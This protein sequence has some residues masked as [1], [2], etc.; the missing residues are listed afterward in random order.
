LRN[1]GI[2]APL[3]GFVAA[4]AWAG[5]PPIAP[6]DQEKIITNHGIDR[7]DPYHW[8]F[9]PLV[10][11]QVVKPKP[12]TLAYLTAEEE[13][14]RGETASLLPLQE[15]L[16]KEMRERTP[17][18]ALTIAPVKIGNYLYSL[19]AVEGKQFRAYYRTRL[20]GSGEQKVLDL[21]EAAGGKPFIFVYEFLPS[22]DGRKL[23]YSSMPGGRE[24]SLYLKDLETGEVQTLRK[25]DLGV[26]VAEGTT[27][28]LWSA[29]EKS[30]F[31][32]VSDTAKRSYQLYRLKLGSG[33][34]A[35]LVYEEKDPLYVLGLSAS[36]DGKY[37]FRNSIAK[38]SSEV[39][40]LPTDK[41]DA[42]WKVISPRSANHIYRA[43][44]RN[45]WFYLWSNHASP[46]YGVYRTQ[47]ART[48]LA[49][50]Q[51]VVAPLSDGS[52]DKLY[53]F[54]NFYVYLARRLGVQSIQ[55]TPFATG[56]SKAVAFSEPVY[57]L[58]TEAIYTPEVM[59]LA[60]NWDYGAEGFRFRFSSMT[61]L[62][63]DIRYEV[64]SGKSVTLQETKLGES[65]QPAAYQVERIF[66]PS[67]NVEVPVSII[68]RK[69]TPKDGTAPLF[70]LGYG[71]YGLNFRMNDMQTYSPEVAASL[72]DRG[73]V[74]AIAHVRGGGEL[75]PAW[76]AGG[77]VM[78]KQNTFRDFIAVTEAL[79]ARK[80]AAKD[81]VAIQS[82][83]AGGLLVGTVINWR[84]ELYRAAVAKQ[85]FVD[86]IN[87]ELD[88]SIPFT[89]Q[90]WTE[91]GNPRDNPEE[92][93]YML[94][95]SPYDNVGKRDYPALLVKTS[96]GDSQV[97][98]HEPAKWVARLRANKTDKNP[99]Y[100]AVDLTGD[101]GGAAGT[102]GQLREVA[103]DFAFVLTQLGI[104]R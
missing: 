71:A 2:L 8:M 64:G 21:N 31:Y 48:G 10:N 97:L 80:Y 79:V 41:P 4:P 16:F 32:T 75:G 98:C 72:L 57:S 22:R 104:A 42:E 26:P 65:F 11:G 14:T 55:V 13:Y 95:Y 88:T 20:D 59:I 99:L 15:T 63:T 93:K 96:I 102:E 77:K 91:W 58:V 56:L 7:P 34:A 81:R 94:E 83:S 37:L 49:S 5:S 62:G 50:W 92:F 68:Y 47:V 39:A 66:V 69:S 74:I 54:R 28:A 44:S 76:Y 70:L 23:L 101:H 103:F 78:N 51:E 89:T 67:G 30:V 27:Q 36:R 90:E 38:D 87:T 9:T 82:H 18:G 25:S 46:N 29:D 19:K 84:P 85:P 35:T 33:E 61:S 1:L 73:V 43:E 40:Y 86:L 45:G 52:I 17:K 60:P 3:L 6:A 53:V 24:Y 12:E 100:L